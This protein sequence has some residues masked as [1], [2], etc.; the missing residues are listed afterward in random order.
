MNT[1]CASPLAAGASCT[2]V[3][4]FTPQNTGALAATVSYF[5]S[6]SSSPQTVALYGTGH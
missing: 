5:D 6:A 4:T 3:I 2:N 1:N